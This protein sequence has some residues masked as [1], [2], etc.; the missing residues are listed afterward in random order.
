MPDFDLQSEPLPFEGWLAPDNFDAT[1]K[2]KMS[3]S[4]LNGFAG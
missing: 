4:A 3:L 1:C 2:Q